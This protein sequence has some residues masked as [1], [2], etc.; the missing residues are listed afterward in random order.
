MLGWIALWLLP[1]TLTEPMKPGVAIAALT[2][3]L[4]ACGSDTA[5]RATSPT[6]STATVPS[7]MSTTTASVTSTPAVPATATTAAQEPG[8]ATTAAATTSDAPTPT[9]APTTTTRV[10]PDGE[11]APDFTL[12]LGQGGT[13]ALSEEQKPVYMVFWAGW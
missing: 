11:D 12:A 3:F 5:P 10:R 4:A 13:F 2:V 6:S 8:T 1:S 7:N 9:P